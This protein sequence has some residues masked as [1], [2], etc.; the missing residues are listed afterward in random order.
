[1][2][3]VRKLQIILGLCMCMIIGCVGCTKR[4]ETS[5]RTDSGN[6]NV[7]SIGDAEK[8]ESQEPGEETDIS[9]TEDMTLLRNYDEISNKKYSWYIVRDDNHGV[10][11][12]D[13]SFSIEQYDAYYANLD[14]KEDEKVMYLT[15]DCGY[16]NGYTD[17]LLDILKEHDAKACFFVTQTYIRDNV[18]LVKR[19]K[20]EGHLVGNHTVRHPSMPEISIDEQKEEL[21]KCA[22]YMK[23]V[24]GYEMDPYY[25]PPRGEYSERSLQFAKDMGYRTI[26]WS[27]AYLDYD[28]NKQPGRDYVITHFKK[29]HHN[30]A[31]PLIHNVSQSNAEALGDVLT[32]LEEE[33]Y[34]FASLREMFE[35]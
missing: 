8:E 23:E 22:D 26:F 16:E 9:T 17:Q 10:S 14:C 32:Y 34:R 4:K 3:A 18:D 6:N 29:Y 31:I 33:G 28:V 13:R 21:R 2:I 20:E 7:A 15:F 27:M 11:G 12:C 19:M 24:T 25:R 35:K 1:M 30:G 5:D